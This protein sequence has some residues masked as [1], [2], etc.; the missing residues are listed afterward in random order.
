MEKLSK[1]VRYGLGFYLLYYLT[2]VVHLSADRYS[3]V[4]L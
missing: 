2:D 3:D 1:R 4:D